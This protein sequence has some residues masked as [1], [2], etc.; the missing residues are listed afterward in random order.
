MQNNESGSVKNRVNA[1]SDAK[2]L[3]LESLLEEQRKRKDRSSCKR[4]GC[5]GSSREHRS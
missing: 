1:L 5:I 4:K 3:L 2:R